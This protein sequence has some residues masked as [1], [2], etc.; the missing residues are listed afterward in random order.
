[1]S[2]LSD[3]LKDLEAVEKLSTSDREK[4]GRLFKRYDRETS[5]LVGSLM[6]YAAGIAGV[7]PRLPESLRYDAGNVMT[8]LLR[9]RAGSQEWDRRI[10]APLCAA[11][12]WKKQEWE[13][14]VALRRQIS[15]RPNE[16]IFGMALGALQG[17]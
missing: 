8:L 15:E 1:M 11:P 3:L 9:F 14:Y 13:L 16:D 12:F 10:L 2:Y 7:A 4:I 5:E 17:L 6:R